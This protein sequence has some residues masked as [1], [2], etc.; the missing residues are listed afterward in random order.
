MGGNDENRL[1]SDSEDDEQDMSSLLA[2]KT[3]AW[4]DRYDANGGSE[5]NPV[6]PWHKNLN[7]TM[8]WM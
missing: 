3:K 7:N 4:Q 6:G 8:F 2:T 1:Y 5:A